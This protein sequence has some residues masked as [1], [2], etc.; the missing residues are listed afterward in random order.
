MNR[1]TPGLTVHHQLP[2]ST[3]T[4][5]HRGSDAIQPSHPL[6]SPSPPTLNLSQH[7][8]LFKWGSSSHQVARVLKFQLQHQSDVVK[9]GSR[10]LNFFR[11][12]T[13]NVTYVIDILDHKHQVNFIPIASM[14]LCYLFYFY[15]FLL[16]FTLQYCIGFA[17]HWHESTTGVY[18]LPIL[19]PPPTSHP[20]SSLWIIPMHQ[21]QAS[22]ILYWT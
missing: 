2:E 14:N 13:E 21:P 1:G 12:C 3:Q 15:F 10:I 7:Q 19:F 22:C 8:G 17:L 9:F 20:I 4:H 5:V 18:K 6:S 11:M 16:Y